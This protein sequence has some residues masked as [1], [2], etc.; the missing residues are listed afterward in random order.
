MIQI[1][2]IIVMYDPYTPKREPFELT[3]NEILEFGES[4]FDPGFSAQVFLTN[5]EVW[6]CVKTKKGWDACMIDNFE[7]EDEKDNEDFEYEGYEKTVNDQG[8]KN[9][10]DID[11]SYQDKRV[12][13]E[14]LVIGTLDTFLSK[15][16]NTFANLLDNLLNY[17]N[18]QPPSTN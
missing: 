18:R 8:L 4:F 11:E 9:E 13:I 12:N 5:G 14:N 16:Q 6:S 3:Y 10:D 7:W 1:D 15:E 17:A 2:Q